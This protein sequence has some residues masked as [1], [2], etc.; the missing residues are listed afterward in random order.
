EAIEQYTKA[1]EMFEEAG[2]VEDALFCW[3]RTAQL[4]PENLARQLKL[5]EAAEGIGK[6]ALAARAFLRAGQLASASGAQAEALDFFG[7]A[8]NLPPQER[9]VA[10]FYAEATLRAGQPGQAAK[11][12]EPFVPTEND[13]H[14]LETFSDALMRSK[15][16]DRAREIMERVLREKNEGAARLF[17]IADL[18]VT[19]GQP[20]KAV[21]ILH[22]LKQRMFADKRQNQFAAQMDGIGAKHSTS[23]PILQFWAALHNELN[24]ES[25]Y[26]E[27]LVKLFDAYLNA[28]NTAKAG[29]TLENLVDIDPYDY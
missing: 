20:A 9:R 17:E 11:L 15:Q 2:R 28:G 24:R 7:R 8:Y 18:Y 25:Q 16:L 4:A 23:Q 12:L 1:A 21:E 19:S 27:V 6:H 26:F 5:A 3:E 22:A 14:F 29:E 10:L 13:T